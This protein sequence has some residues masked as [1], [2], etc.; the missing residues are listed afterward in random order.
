MVYEVIQAHQDDLGVSIAD[1]ALEAGVS[2]STVSR[3]IR[4]LEATH[5]ITV[6]QGR[7]RSTSTYQVNGIHLIPEGNPIS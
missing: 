3:S 2:E 5:L 1:I 4:A 6:D 7:G